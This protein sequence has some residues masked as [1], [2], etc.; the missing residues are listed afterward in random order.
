M[1]NPTAV[2]HHVNGKIKQQQWRDEQD[3]LHRD[4]DLPAVVVW[5]ESGKKREEQW[6]R[7]GEP[8]RDGGGPTT[9]AYHVNGEIREQQWRDEQGQLHRDGD[10]PA[11]VV[12]DERGNK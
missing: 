6:H 12:W 5:D 7:H 2:L 1:T 3:R 11:V 9:V 10:L 4:G 8:F